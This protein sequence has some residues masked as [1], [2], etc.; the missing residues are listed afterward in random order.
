MTRFLVFSDLHLGASRDHRV[1]ALADHR[2]ALEQIVDTAREHDVDTVLFGGDAFHHWKPSPVEEHAFQAFTR[3]LEAAGIPMV[4]VTGN[5]PHD[6][7]SVDLPSA[8]E[9][10]RSDWVRVSRHPEVVKAA[11]DVA[12]CTLPSVPVS[13]L[14]AHQGGG[15]RGAIFEL[16]ASMLVGTARDL[17]DRVPAGWPSILLAHFSVSGSSL[18]TGLPVA[19]LHEPVLPLDALEEIGFDAIALGHIHA[20]QMFSSNPLEPKIPVFYPGPPMTLN[21]GDAG[22]EHGVYILDVGDGPATT[23]FVPLTDRRFVT[24]TVDLTE[25]LP[26][27]DLVDPTGAVVSRVIGLDETDIIAAA[28]AAEVFNLPDA[29]VRVKYRA[30]EEQHRRIDHAALEGFL[31]EAGAHRLYGGIDWDPVRTTR[32]RQEGL[33]E[34]IEPLAA[35]GM[36]I[37]ANSVDDAP[38]RALRDLTAGYLEAVAA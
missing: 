36:W 18:P 20:Q 27:V 28:I 34:S 6:I 5:T 7:G 29:V 4:A 10:F 21:F 13:R 31:A 9:L 26:M 25:A 15:D 3:A 38:G 8:L 16:A 12:I 17:Y 30:T 24:V 2:R 14:V 1:D 33:D 35:V 22:F 32:A 11:G 19:G 37:D 23:E